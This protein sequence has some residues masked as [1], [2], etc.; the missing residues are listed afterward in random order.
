MII[1]NGN[2]DIQYNLY[3]DFM[4]SCCLRPKF[5]SE[6]MIILYFV[7]Y[8]SYKKDTEY[9]RPPKKNGI[10]CELKDSKMLFFISVV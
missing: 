4:I 3:L 5:S 10:F 1:Y 9:H 6:H 8:Y 2:K 7:T